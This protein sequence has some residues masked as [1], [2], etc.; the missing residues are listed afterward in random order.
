MQNEKQIS[1]MLKVILYIWTYLHNGKYTINK[2]T[3]DL[4]YHP[5]LIS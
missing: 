1:A 3:T 2:M 5:L 4:Y